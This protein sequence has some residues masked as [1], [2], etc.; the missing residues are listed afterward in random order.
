MS[1]TA[2]KSIVQQDVGSYV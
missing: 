2:C 1:Y